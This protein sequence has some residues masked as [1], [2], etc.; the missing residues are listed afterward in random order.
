MRFHR[1]CRPWLLSS[2]LF[3][4]LLERPLNLY[5]SLYYC[6]M[7]WGAS[8]LK[9]YLKVYACHTNNYRF[10]VFAL[11]VYA[12]EQAESLPSRP[13]AI[14]FFFHLIIHILQLV[15][16]ISDT[17]VCLGL[18]QL[19]DWRVPWDFDILHLQEPSIWYSIVQPWFEIRL[20]ILN[21]RSRMV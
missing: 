9:P 11:A 7:G 4:D 14:V 21:R 17:Q 8:H 13:L 10:W 18:V 19:S 5:L 20:C 3:R 15:Q 16:A 6:T 12:A 2:R 1:W